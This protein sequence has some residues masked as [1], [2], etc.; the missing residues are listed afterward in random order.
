MNLS[1]EILTDLLIPNNL[2]PDQ[3]FLDN[4]TICFSSFPNLNIINNI[5]LQLG[6]NIHFDEK[7]AT[8]ENLS[9]CDG[10]ACKEVGKTAVISC[11]E[12]VKASIDKVTAEKGQTVAF[13]DRCKK[14]VKGKLLQ[15][16]VFAYYLQ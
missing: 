3:N 4:Q 11:K 16:M 8:D 12:G 7:T 9:K 2:S 10:I 6:E 13:D 5:R 14:S 15:N 1:L